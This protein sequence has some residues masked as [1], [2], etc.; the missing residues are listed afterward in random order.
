MTLIPGAEPEAGGEYEVKLRGVPAPDVGT[1]VM[2]SEGAKVGGRVVSTRVEGD[3]TIV[4]LRFTKLSDLLD[5][6]SLSLRWRLEDLELTNDDGSPLA[7]IPSANLLPG[8][9]AKPDGKFP[10]S[11]L[12]CTATAS[13]KL[14]KNVVDVSLGKTGELTYVD[15]RDDPTLPSSFSR[16]RYQGEITL[17]GSIGL[18]A[19]GS[20]P[21]DGTARYGAA[22]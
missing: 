18:K 19:M 7:T 21:S 17:T 20:N 14:S 4:R 3:L 22:R 9:A 15:G 6:Y 1:V 2:A 12:S 13:A 8:V 10:P 5:R 16:L 11:P